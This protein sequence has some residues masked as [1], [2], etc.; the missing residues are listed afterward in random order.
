MKVRE[1]FKICR[2]RGKDG[3][4]DALGKECNKLNIR[5]EI[6]LIQHVPQNQY[7]GNQN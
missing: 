7:S 1:T 5:L 2:K 4:K 6:T 3:S